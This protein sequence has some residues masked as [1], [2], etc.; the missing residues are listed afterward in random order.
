MVSAYV[1]SKYQLLVQRDR[2]T[3]S[4]T[5]RTLGNIMPPAPIVK[6]KVLVQNR[7]VYIIYKLTNFMTRGLNRVQTTNHSSNDI[8]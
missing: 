2:Q 4:R 8:R 5:A 3:E 1:M 7:R 6:M